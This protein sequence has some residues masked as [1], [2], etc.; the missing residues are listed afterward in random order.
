VQVKNLERRTEEDVRYSDVAKYLMGALPRFQQ[1]A[2]HL[3][4]KDITTAFHDEADERPALD[5]TRRGSRRF[6]RR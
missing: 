1:A 3:Q 5:E 2:K 4:Q 6:E